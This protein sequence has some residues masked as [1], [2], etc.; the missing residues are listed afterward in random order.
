MMYVTIYL[1]KPI[2]YATPRVNPKVNCGVWMIMLCQRRLIFGKNYTTL[3]S[4]IDNGYACA[5]ARSV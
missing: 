1:S 2:E 4:D 5:E 3:V